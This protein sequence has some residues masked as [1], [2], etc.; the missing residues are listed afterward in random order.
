MAEKSRKTNV[1]AHCGTSKLVRLF[2]DMTSRKYTIIYDVNG[3]EVGRAVG[4][5]GEFS[6]ESINLVGRFVD[7]AGYVQYHAVSEKVDNNWIKIGDSIYMIT[8]IG[9]RKTSIQVNSSNLDEADHYAIVDKIVKELALH[10]IA[11][12]DGEC[13]ITITTRC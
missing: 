12:L 3:D 9:E 13:H 8:K 6:G 7:A 10:D 1:V 2:P 5:P 4:H 11:V